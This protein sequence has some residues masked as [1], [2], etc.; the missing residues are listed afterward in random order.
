MT[1][2][3][4][5][6]AKK[7]MAKDEPATP[8]YVSDRS[9]A[10]RK[11]IDELGGNAL[12]ARKLNEKQQNINNWIT[13]GRIPSTSLQRLKAVWLKEAGV[14]PA[15]KKKPASPRAL[16]AGVLVPAE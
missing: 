7:A 16:V 15:A 12:A 10:V 1:E 14:V 4:K 9:K 2:K 8:R 6:T 3:T 5:P 13:R 11:I